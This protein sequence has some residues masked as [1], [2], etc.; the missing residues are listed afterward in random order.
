MTACTG[1]VMEPIDDVDMTVSSTGTMEFVFCTAPKATQLTVGQ[2]DKRVTPYHDQTLWVA[3]STGLLV[4]DPIAFGVAPPSFHTTFGPTAV[5][6]GNHWIFV[7]AQVRDKSGVLVE[8]HSGQFDGDK[9]L[10]GKWLD[11]SGR[12]S[13]KA[14]AP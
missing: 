3:D 8:Q 4:S 13:D 2:V 6:M 11:A 9:A 12:L 5:T 7:Y 1:L 14:C 10:P